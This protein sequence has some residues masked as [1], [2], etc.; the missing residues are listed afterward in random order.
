MKKLIIS[1]IIWLF[2]IIGL[3]QVQIGITYGGSDTYSIHLLTKYAID[4]HGI[5]WVIELAQF[6]SNKQPKFPFYL[7]IDGKYRSSEGAQEYYGSKLLGEINELAE[8]IEK[9]K[10]PFFTG[11]VAE[12]PY[13]YPCMTPLELAHNFRTSIYRRESFND[14]TRFCIGSLY[15]YNCR[16]LFDNAKQ[17]FSDEEDIKKEML[18]D[19]DYLLEI[20]KPTESTLDYGITTDYFILDEEERRDPKNLEYFYS[21]CIDDYSDFIRNDTIK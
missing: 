21:D 16:C 13:K 10:L 12:F 1:I 6:Y 8:Y 19:L 18:R 11:F 20:F 3:G 7:G 9:N 17:K 15:L 2:P 4:C 5:D 14:L